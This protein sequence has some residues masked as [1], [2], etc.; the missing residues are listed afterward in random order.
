M[1]RINRLK[2]A[3]KTI[4]TGN[5]EDKM[6]NL[7]VFP[8]I[9]EFEVTNHCNFQCLMCKTGVGTSKRERGYMT[10]EVFHKAIKE[11]V[12]NTVGEGIL[13]FVGQGEPLMHPKIMEYIK[14][15]KENGIIVH[16]T[17]NGSLLNETMMKELID[18]KLDSIKFSF[19]G[20]NAEGYK[21]LR[22]KDD[23]E[24]LLEKIEKLYHLRGEN[25][26]PYITIGTSVTNEKKEE[27]ENFRSRCKKICDKVEIGITTLEFIDLNQVKSEKVKNELQK[28][29]DEQN[30]V[31]KRYV[32]CPQVY[33]T[34]AVRWNGDITACCADLDGVMTL[35][36]ILDSSIIQCWNSPLE[37][38]YRQILLKCDYEKLEL[39]KDCYDVYGWTY[40]DN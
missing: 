34:I 30:S 12:E 38:K 23:F 39:C 36:N 26:F 16:V 15:A 17:T 29:Q 22:Q 14:S 27:I 6:R 3:Y 37:N 28:I 19:Q 8:K 20:I 1:E 31:K 33:D 18:T 35:G 10:D 5:A 32:C 9:I 4:D 13:K 40:G 25:D 2:E 21:T 11:V 24:D 7:P